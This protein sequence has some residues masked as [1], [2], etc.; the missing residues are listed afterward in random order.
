MLHLKHAF[1]RWFPPTLAWLQV[2]ITSHCPGRCTY[3]PHEAYRSSWRS[4]H[5]SV[6]TFERI[7]PAMAHAGLVHLQGWGEPLSHPRLRLLLDMAASTGCKLST[8][9]N[10]ML[11]DDAVFEQLLRFDLLSFSL[12]GVGAR[13]DS[14]RTGTS[15]ARIMATI[16]RLAS[17]KRRYR[18]TKP[19]IHVSYLLLQSGVDALGEV[20]SAL[21][22]RGIAQVIVSTLD[23]VPSPEISA[24]AVLPQTMDAHRHL[25][26]RLDALIDDAAARGLELHYCLYRPGAKRSPCTENV[27]RALFVAADGSVSPCV[28]TNLPV[29]NARLRG[30]GGERPFARLVFGSVNETPLRTIWGQA[31]YRRFRNDFARGRNHRV[32]LDCPK[33]FAVCR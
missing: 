5:M 30:L 32:C 6:E 33:L 19:E 20:P 21:S 13:N 3:C 31:D 16:E 11:P 10:G 17:H 23:F 14:L 24:E 18:L 28:F 29:A 7:L 15:F 9:S 12:A 26:T 8:T 4:Q 22:G 2:E 1:D 27:T 25:V